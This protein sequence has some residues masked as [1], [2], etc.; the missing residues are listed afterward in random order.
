MPLPAA[1]DFAPYA[2]L[3]GAK[4]LHHP[5]AG[6]CFVCEGRFLVE[7]ALKDA[8]RLRIL[9]VLASERAADAFQGRLPEGV[10]LLSLPDGKLEALVGFPFHRGVL[11]CI[12][13]P[14]EPTVEVLH[15]ARR[16][17]VLPRLDNVDNL[18]NLLRTAAALGL[19]GVLAGSGPGLFD[20]R[21]IRVS[22]GAAWRLPVWQRTDDTALAELLASWRNA[23]GGEVAAAALGEDAVL[24]RDW[25]P[26]DA[27]ALM[28]GPEG[29]GL[30]AAWLARCDRAVRIPMAHGMDSLN[31]AAAGAILMARQ[32]GLN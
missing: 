9:S 10:P 19:E 21:T 29:P 30:D 26:A 1:S 12:A 27:S 16:I 17:L 15:A 22:M 11:A 7:E 23:T 28:L 5:E 4:T 18:G 6:P 25:H 20:R 32:L 2:Q 24:L 3:H 8:H 13:L 31:V 14:P